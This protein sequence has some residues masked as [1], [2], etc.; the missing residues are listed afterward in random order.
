MRFKDDSMK[1]S[2]IRLTLLLAMIMIILPCQVDKLGTINYLSLIHHIQ[3]V[4]SLRHEYNHYFTFVSQLN[5]SRYHSV[6]TSTAYI[7]LSCKQLISGQ[8]LANVPPHRGI[9]RTKTNAVL[10][11]VRVAMIWP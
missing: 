7:S 2:S 6:P 9:T 11:R 5:R 4:L 8:L 3:I 1:I 10:I